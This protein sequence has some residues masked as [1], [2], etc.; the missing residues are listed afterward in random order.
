MQRTLS[1]I[2]TTQSRTPNADDKTD[3]ILRLEWAKSRARANRCK[4]EVL[5]LREEMHQ[6]LVFLEWKSDWW[7][8]RQGLREGVG[9]ALDEG[10]RAFAL[11]QSDVQQRLAMH[12][13]EIWCSPLDDVT[14]NSPSDAVDNPDCEDNGNNDDDDEDDEDNDNDDNKGE[15]EQDLEEDDEGND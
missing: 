5:L 10:L 11:E 4:E 1:W 7:L 3:D 9:R 6:T 8:Q 2:W 15:C 13:Q 14:A 12:F